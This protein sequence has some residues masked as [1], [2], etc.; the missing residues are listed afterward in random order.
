MRSYERGNAAHAARTVI[1]Y[2]ND[3][4]KQRAR[5]DKCDEQ[6]YT[7]STHFIYSRKQIPAESEE[8]DIDSSDILT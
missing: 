3:K 1:L 8:N 5:N 2:E 7:N 4:D 6:N